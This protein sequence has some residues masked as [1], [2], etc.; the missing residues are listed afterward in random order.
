MMVNFARIEYINFKGCKALVQECYKGALHLQ[1]DDDSR[2]QDATCPS[3]V[4]N[5][6]HRGCIELDVSPLPQAS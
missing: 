1:K 3:P 6:D 2:E 5:F 4:T